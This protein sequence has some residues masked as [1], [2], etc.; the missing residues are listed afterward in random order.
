MWGDHPSPI[1]MGDGMGYGWRGIGLLRRRGIGCEGVGI[2][3]F[4]WVLIFLI[5]TNFMDIMDF[6]EI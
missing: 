5:H 6:I 4:G 2:G 3:S 1:S